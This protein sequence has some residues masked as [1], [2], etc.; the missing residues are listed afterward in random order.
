M[1]WRNERKAWL[2][3]SSFGLPRIVAIAIVVAATASAGFAQVTVETLTSPAVTE[4][5]PYYQDVEDAIARFYSRDVENARNLLVAAKKK[6]PKLAPPE[7][8]LAQLFISA[9]Q[10]PAA[11]Q[12]LERAIAR[13]SEDPEAYLILADVAFNDQRFTEAGLLFAKAAALAGKFAENPK[14]KQN[15]QMRGFAGMAAVEEARENWAAAKEHLSAWVKLEPNSAAPHQRLARVL[16]QLGEKKEAYAELQAAVKADPKLPPAEIA[17][18]NFYAQAGDKV[19]AEKFMSAAAA[20]GKNDLVTNLALVQWFIQNNQI[21]EALEH[22]DAALKLDPNSLDA[23]VARGVVARMQQNYAEAK[24][25]L[26]AAHTQSPGNPVVTNQLALVL[27]E[28][29]DESDHKRALE[30]AEVNQKLNP[31]N[32]EAAATLG[33]VAYRLGRK[34]DAM[35][36]LNAVTQTGNLTSESAYYV[37]YVLKD[38][39]Q[40][41]NAVKLLETALNNDRPFAYR[42]E[43]EALL[44]ELRK[45]AKESPAA[46][47]PAPE[48]GK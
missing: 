41:A 23:K 4:V 43:A 6:Q 17:M 39:G 35:R 21:S 37:A 30:F 20:R 31:N 1:S 7:V 25:W 11:R 14:R 44:S 36:A 32:V 2:A 40:V 27:L 34:G 5:G 47:T 8:M 33:W 3:T 12:E 19:Q 45:K 10:A 15:F 48:D 42:R 9:G 13:H 24:Q 46:E 18:G 29:K 28:Q 22:A 16:F 26:E 38:Q